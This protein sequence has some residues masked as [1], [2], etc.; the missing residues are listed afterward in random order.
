MATTEFLKTRVSPETKR[1]IRGLA[2]RQFVTESALLKRLVLQELQASEKGGN[3]SDSGSGPIS[4]DRQSG[5][6]KAAGGRHQRICLRL[7]REDLLLLEACAG[8]RGMRPATYASV[9]MRSHLHHITPL[10]KDEL[11]A[12]KRSISQL[13]SIGRNLNQVVRHMHQGK[14]PASVRNEFEMMLKICIGLRDHTKALLKEN[15]TSWSTGNAKT[16]I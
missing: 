15:A 1:R 9:L 3:G 11:L 8:A 13:G 10:P 16:D 4:V 6:R 14:V 12:F 5:G 7:R 2:E